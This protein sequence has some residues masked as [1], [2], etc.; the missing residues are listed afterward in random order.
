MDHSAF[1][2]LPLVSY[3][4]AA[5]IL[6]VFLYV[7]PRSFFAVRDLYRRPTAVSLSSISLF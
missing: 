4:P 6:Y 1:V 7:T 3:K 5:F 2:L